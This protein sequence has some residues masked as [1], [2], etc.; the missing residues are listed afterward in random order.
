MGG[1]GISCLMERVCV[2]VRCGL[3]DGMFADAVVVV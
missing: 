1:R 2:S 3:E